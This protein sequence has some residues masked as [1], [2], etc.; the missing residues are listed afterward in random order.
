MMHWSPARIWSMHTN[1]SPS[2]WVAW[3]APPVCQWPPIL[4]RTLR[5]FNWVDKAWKLYYLQTLCSGRDKSLKNAI[6]A[7][8][9]VSFPTSRSINSWIAPISAEKYCKGMSNIF[10]HIYIHS[11]LDLKFDRN[12]FNWSSYFIDWFT[13]VF[14][15]LMYFKSQI[16]VNKNITIITVINK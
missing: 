11:P 4:F 16:T 14:L 9:F 8:E 6:F 5:V 2:T 12:M 10:P 1:L 15:S 3:P 13:S 7:S